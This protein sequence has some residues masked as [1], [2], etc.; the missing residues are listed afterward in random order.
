MLA[1]IHLIGQKG[2]D[3]IFGK[4]K[5]E[6]TNKKGKLKKL[7]KKEERIEKKKLKE[8]GISSSD[9]GEKLEDHPIVPSSPKS[10]SAD[11]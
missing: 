8:I 4:P 10:P 9:I 5:I 11:G 1:F 6:K 2:F 7:L 3:I